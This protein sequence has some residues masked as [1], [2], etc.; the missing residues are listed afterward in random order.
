[1]YS[2]D[3]KWHNLDQDLN[4]QAGTQTPDKTQIET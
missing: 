4:P 1:M 2:M 3:M